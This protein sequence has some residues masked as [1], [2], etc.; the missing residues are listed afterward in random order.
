V[1][2]L[3][4]YVVSGFS[5]T[6]T[7]EIIMMSRSL[8]LTALGLLTIAAPLAAQAPAA[9]PAAANK[10]K[11]RNPAALKETAPEKY[12]AKFDTSAGVFVIEV[13]RA[14]APLGADRFYNLVKNGFYDDVRFFRVLDGFMAQFGMNGDPTVQAPWGKANFND[15]P[16]KESNK[17]GTVTFAKTSLPNSRSTQVFINFV[18]NSASLDGQ[19]FAPFGRIT[20][21][22]D[23]VDKLY[24]GYG[25]NNV[26]DQ[27]RITTEGNAYLTKTYPK[28]D[29]VKKAT[30]EP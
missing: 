18:D 25:R 5:R 28:L 10:A 30:I 14:W 12:N 6:Q 8:A 13:T 9:A 3:K 29:Y 27:G 4:E 7:K 20:Q 16:V 2:G 19:G 1:S 23:V 24:S 15:D 11:L 17:R 21:G 22:M 26:P